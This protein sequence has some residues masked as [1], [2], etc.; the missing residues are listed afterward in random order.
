MSRTSFQAIVLAA[1]KSSRFKS[2]TTKLLY[3]LCGQEMILYPLQLLQQFDIPMT[4][5]IG[6]KKELIKKL[7]ERHHID[8]LSF[9]EQAQ[10]RG[11]GDAVAATIHTWHAD[12]I[13]VMNG[14]VPLVPSSVLRE[15]MD[16]HIAT[17]ATITLAVAHNIDP[18]AASGFG[19][20]MTREGIMSIVEARDYKGDPFADCCINAG[21]YIFKREFLKRYI[22][23]LLPHENAQEMYLPDLIEIASRKK[24]QITTV[25][26]PF[27][28]VRGVNTLKELWTAEQ[29]KRSEIIETLMQQGVRFTYAQST[30]IDINVTI[31]AGS[32]IESGV[33]LLAG[34]RIGKECTIGAF[35]IISNTRLDDRVI[36]HSHS[37]I[38]DATI[39]TE[40]T[41]GPFAYIHRNSVVGMGSIIGNFVEV[42][43]SSIAQHTKI[44]HLSYIGNAIIGS[45]VNIG[46]G[47]IICNYNGITKNNTIIDDHVFI[48][49]NN[50]LIAPLHIAKYAM[51]AAGSVITDN[52]PEHALAIARAKQE[53]KLGYADK[54]RN[55]IA[56][57]GASKS[58][59]TPLE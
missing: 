6:Y 21:I 19:R 33:Q 47:T 31:G 52:V 24:L 54:I 1:G 49:S 44:K 35:S 27:D 7:F 3:T 56:I 57:G 32:C 45:Y 43:K 17:S 20:V 28:Q 30:H 46:A 51:T 2:D 38:H 36:V 10:Q 12:H 42:S 22:G 26:A 16:Q 48:G 8:S 9:V 40:A 50:A 18:I 4:L 39:G 58:P 11:T 41:I 15:L 34:T 29:I 37:I 14:D 5:V 25:I 13:I 55:P 23:T 59:S 53:T